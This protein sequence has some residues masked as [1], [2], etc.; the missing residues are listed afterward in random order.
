MRIKTTV[1]TASLALAALLVGAPAANAASADT[2]T[3]PTTPPAS[4]AGM[5]VTG[6]DRAV[7]KANGYEIRTDANGVERSV[8]VGAAGQVVPDSAPGNTIQGNCGWSWVRVNGTGNRA[9]LLE[10]G[11]GVRLPVIAWEWHIVLIDRGGVSTQNWGPT[12]GPGVPQLR[13]SR[14]LSNLTPGSIAAEV[15]SSSR[16]T[17]TDGA[18]CVSGV[19]ADH[20]TVT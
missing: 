13:F 9:I 12:P 1:V 8:K 11:F 4:G 5:T 14:N 17:L 19:H 7:A 18:I 10:S 6:F 15:Q 20:G 3:T 2:G 16:V